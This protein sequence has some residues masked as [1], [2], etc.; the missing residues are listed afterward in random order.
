[1]AYNSLVCTQVE[2]ASVV[3]S[4]YTKDNMNKIEK[5]QRRAARWVL[6]DCSSYSSRG[7]CA[8]LGGRKIFSICRR[9][10]VLQTDASVG[11]MK[12][13]VSRKAPEPIAK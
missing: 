8:A 4:P 2:Y 7:Y 6:N 5:V 1:M 13:V 11:M 10:P 3:W 9:P 12:I